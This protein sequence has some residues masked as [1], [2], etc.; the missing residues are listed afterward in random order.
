MPGVILLTGQAIEAKG[1]VIPDTL[2][3]LGRVERRSCDRFMHRSILTRSLPRDPIDA[4]APRLR[5][6]DI[7]LP[8]GRRLPTLLARQPVAAADLGRVESA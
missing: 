2:E 7:H 6:G 8:R 5:L 1:R 3:K 4:S